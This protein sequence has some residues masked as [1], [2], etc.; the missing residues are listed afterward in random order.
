MSFKD[1]RN[2]CTQIL[3]FCS[4]FSDGFSKTEPCHFAS[5]TKL[6]EQQKQC[7]LQ[8]KSNK[9]NTKSKDMYFQCRGNSS[10]G[11]L[12]PVRDCMTLTC[13]FDNSLINFALKSLMA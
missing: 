2:L 6:T 11:L 4:C 8:D 12:K 13:E 10:K 7:H 1:L 3:T 5:T 9:T